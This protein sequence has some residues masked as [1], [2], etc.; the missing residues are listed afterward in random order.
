MKANVVTSEPANSQLRQIVRLTLP[1][2]H[3]S[4]SLALEPLALGLLA[5]PSAAGVPLAMAALAGFFLRRPLKLVMSS[6]SDLRRTPALGCV[7][8]LA[9]FAIANLLLA[10]RAGGAPG[11][12]LLIPAALA[13]MIFAWFDSRGESR[14]GAAE[15]A[16]ATAFGLLPAAFAALAGWSVI[17]S[18]AIAVVM[19]VRSL[20]TVLF[21]RT[22]LRRHKGRS[23]TTAPALIAAGAGF[24]LTVWLV[25]LRTAPWPATVFAFLLAARTYWLLNGRN[26]RI[27]ARTMGMT[28]MALGA[29]MVL[30]LAVTW[31]SL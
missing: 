14:Q 21:V 23:V 15:L 31:K 22:Y 20:P 29:A 11:L 5:A 30:T 19:L 1:R 26:L 10:A 18:V 13:G 16:G 9:T 7:I 17:Q 12:W 8:V 3:G 4:W 6:K 28:E 27:A 24:F 25:L 2:E